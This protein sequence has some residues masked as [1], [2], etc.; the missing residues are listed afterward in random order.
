MDERFA[1]AERILRAQPFSRLLGTRLLAF[2]PGRAELAL[3][4]R[5]EHRQQNGFAHGGVLAY[6]VDNAL[7]F[8][9]GS[10]LGPEVLTVEFKVNFVR[11]ARGDELRAVGEAK[12][13]GKRLAVAR[14]EVYDGATL[15]ALGQGTVAAAG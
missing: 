6:L 14:A 10:V 3:R 4:L 12:A 9:A 13:A 5:P 8:A 2:R 1:L 7:T 15:V 11:P